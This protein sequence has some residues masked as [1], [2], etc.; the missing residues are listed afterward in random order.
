MSVPGLAFALW[1]AFVGT[2]AAHEME[3]GG[4]AA[5]LTAVFFLFVCRKS[6]LEMTLR[7]TDVAELWRVPW[8]VVSDSWQITGV[9]VKDLLGTSRAESLFRVCGFDAKCDDPE[10]TGRRVL[11][12]A[13]TSAAP[14]AIVI[15]TDVEQGRMLFHQLQR[16]EL[17]ATMKKLG[18]HP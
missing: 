12:T 1:F 10:G 6:R 8:Y 16:S 9:L 17:T 14:N 13:Y 3:V 18:A 15:G 4:A 7:A 11:A 5:L 2:R